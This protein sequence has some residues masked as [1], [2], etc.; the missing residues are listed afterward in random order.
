MTPT[1]LI[2]AWPPVMSLPFV[3]GWI[4]F[5]LPWSGS[6]HFTGIQHFRAHTL[7]YAS[8]SPISLCPPKIPTSLQDAFALLFTGFLVSN[9]S[10]PARISIKSENALFLKHKAHT[11]MLISSPRACFKKQQKKKFECCALHTQMLS[12]ERALGRERERWWTVA[13]GQGGGLGSDLKQIWR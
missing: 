1:S 3:K 9:N 7:T 12:R 11:V 4:F 10:L 8:I 2:S 6:L 13:R 5:F